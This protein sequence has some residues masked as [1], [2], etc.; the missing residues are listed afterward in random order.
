MQITE[1]QLLQ[2][3]PKAGARAAEFVAPLNSTMAYYG[4]NTPQRVGAFLAQV[5]HE[6]GQLRYVRELG[7]DAYLSKYDTGALAKRLGNTPEA[8]GDGQMYRGRG[9]IQ[10]TGRS[11]Y[12]ACSLALFRDDR[13]LNQPQLLEQPIWA[14]MSAGWYWSTHRLNELADAGDFEAI[15]R[16]ING[17][18]NGQDDR[19]ALYDQ[20]LKVLA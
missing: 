5:G 20:S 6:S 19:L 11:N 3:M 17:G 1:E 10:I 18:L 13:L 9:L 2:I 16:R 4:I 7:G 15:T 14:A 12:L 8:D